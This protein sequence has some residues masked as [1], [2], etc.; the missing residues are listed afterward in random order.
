MGTDC[1]T[2]SCCGCFCH[3][4]IGILI[5]LFGLTFLLGHLG[6]ISGELVGIIWPTLIVL[7][8]LKK[9]FSG[10]CKCCDPK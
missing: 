2:G 9:T 4:T 8:G 10:L 5:V 7:G 3:K 1:G 6:V